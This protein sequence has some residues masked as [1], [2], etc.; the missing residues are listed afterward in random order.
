[1]KGIEES[2]KDFEKIQK[3]WSEALNVYS[4]AEI[5]KKGT[6]NYWSIGQIYLHLINSTIAFHG[7]QIELCVT[8]KNE[9]NS[10][11]NFKGFMVYNIL[12]KFPPVKIKVQASSDY[13]PNAPMSKSE[14]KLGLEEV[15]R[16]MKLW[17]DLLN[18]DLGGK[19]PHPGFG[20]LNAQEWF[21]LIPMHW[22]HHLRQKRDRDKK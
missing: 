6:D 19:T 7:K 5:T 17:K 1:M 16:K 2:F 12:G 11:K 14:V 21:A 4:E 3:V 13:T 8:T 22:Q 20:F 15:L 10:K 9:G 18:N